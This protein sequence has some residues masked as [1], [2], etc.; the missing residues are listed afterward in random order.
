VIAFQLW[1]DFR[2]RPCSQLYQSCSGVC[3]P[4]EIED[5]GPVEKE[6]IE[7][8][9]WIPFSIAA[10]GLHWPSEAKGKKQHGES[11][12]QIDE[13]H[14][15][16]TNDWFGRYASDRRQVNTDSGM[17]EISSPSAEMPTGR[18]TRVDGPCSVCRQAAPLMDGV[19][20]IPN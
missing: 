13:A 8:V 16:Q 10:D 6:G 18:T 11:Q 14:A 17:G 7:T 3:E 9:S 5:I 2:L 20:C 15:A 1:H 4:T 19:L 12:R